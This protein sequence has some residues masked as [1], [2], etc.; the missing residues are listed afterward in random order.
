MNNEAIQITIPDSI[1]EQAAQQQYEKKTDAPNEHGDRYN[2]A[3]RYSNNSNDYQMSTIDNENELIMLSFMIKDLSAVKYCLD[4]NVDGTWFFNDDTR[5]F[6]HRVVQFYKEHHSL[7]TKKYFMEKIEAHFKLKNIKDPIIAQYEQF[8]DT[9]LSYEFEPEDFQIKFSEWRDYVV[10]QKILQSFKNFAEYKRLGKP[11]A[12]SYEKLMR[13]INGVGKLYEDNHGTYRKASLT[14]DAKMVWEDFY[15]RKIN[16]DIYCG[17]T[18]GYDALDERFSGIEKGKMTII[19]GLSSSGKTSLARCITRHIQ[20]KYGAKICVISC[21]ESRLEYM[22]KIVCAE[23]KLPLSMGNKGRL[24]QE[25]LDD[26]LRK[27]EEIMQED[28]NGGCY[29]II[30]VDARKYT[31]DELEAIIEEEYGAGYFD[32]VLLDHLSLIRAASKSGQDEH[33]ELGDVAKFFRD[34]ARRYNFAGILI[35]QANRSSIRFVRQKREV[36]MFL[37]NIEGS[38]KP[39]QDTDKALAIRLRSDDP[40]IA[41]IKVVKDREGERDYEIELYAR[42]DQCRFENMSVNES[43]MGEITQAAYD[44]HQL[45]LEDGGFKDQ[46]SGKKIDIPIKNSENVITHKEEPITSVLGGIMNEGFSFGHK[47]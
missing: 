44:S 24:N 18:T 26:V 13:D 27:T 10:D 12:S 23:L 38:N 3:A 30:E 35:A 7:F 20:K 28:E 21:E 40:T 1:I 29:E 4:N 19:M 5:A 33:I 45:V 22:K 42:L 16:P 39:G 11:V 15:N 37:E 41:V 36:D 46:R 32:V 6:F 8:Y 31:I 47:D 2:S 14:K 17:Y 9:L 25:Q 34:M 43:F